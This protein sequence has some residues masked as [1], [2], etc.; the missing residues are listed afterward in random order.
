MKGEITMSYMDRIEKLLAD[1]GEASVNLS[2]VLISA[3][4]IANKNE[5]KVVVRMLLEALTKKKAFDQ[6]MIQIINNLQRR[7]SM[8]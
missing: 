7:E 4:E 6:T 3:Y 1:S 5:D 8:E 2:R